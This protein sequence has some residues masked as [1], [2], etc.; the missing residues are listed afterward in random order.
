MLLNKATTD[1][2]K[3]RIYC[4]LAKYY[5]D[6]NIDTAEIYI[7]QASEL[8]N[9]GQ[10]P[11]LQ[12]SV[13]LVKADINY[14]KGNFLNARD[15]Y[16]KLIFLQ[17]TI[18]DIKRLPQTYNGL[19][20][21][22]LFLGELDSSKTFFS[23]SLAEY[24]R[25]G[26]KVGIGE[27][28]NNLGIINTYSGDY[29]EA[30][31]YLLKSAKIDEELNNEKGL[32]KVY[33]NIGLLYDDFKEYDNALKYYKLSLAI[34]E[35]LN[36]KKGLYSVLNNLGIVYK[37]LGQYEESLDCYKRAGFYGRSLGY[38]KG[39]GLTY[40]N[41]GLLYNLENNHL[42]ALEYHQKALAIEK[43]LEDSVRIAVDYINIAD[44]YRKMGY[45]TKG[46]A[47][48]KKG[49]EILEESKHLKK[50]M[51][52][53]EI[54]SET[55]FDL[56]EYEK[57]LSSYRY[58]SM[59]S[60]SIYNIE[61]NGQIAD[62][63]T[64]YET[65]KKEKEIL[66]LKEKTAQQE[67]QQAENKL[68]LE[69]RKKWI[70]GLVLG[71]A[72][73]IFLSLFLI[74]RNRRIEMAKRDAAIIR[75]RELGLK[76]VIE[77]Q[78]EE[79]KRIAKDLHDGIGQQLSGLKMAWQVL[80]K[81]ISNKTP[82][83]T[84]SLKMLTKTLDETTCEVRSI[85][86]QMM[87]RA[88]SEFGLVPAIQDMLKKCLDPTNLKYEFE[89]FKVEGRFAEN[90]EISLYRIT[91]ELVNNV[92]KHSGATEIAV[93]LIKSKS[94]LL[95]IVEDNGSGFNVKKENDGIGLMNIKSRLNTINGEVNFEPSPNSGM[96][97]TIRIP[98]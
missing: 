14:E 18:N 79:R 48:I 21:T 88:L 12:I 84:K 10:S 25:K 76:A 92:I 31:Q 68:E 59:L 77:G 38:Q 3:A 91:Q 74:Q 49:I 2:S 97:A 9:N 51:D 42:L 95:L 5:Q 52:A 70:V 16:M 33:N 23:L 36:D 82:E 93:Q 85:S 15:L 57:A 90:V 28:T 62:I 19:G 58:F 6:I 75:E 65:E 35:R 71:I 1:T 64:K 30:I 7:N 11:Y 66:V 54:L 67:R 13:Y 69:N 81:R 80:S 34:R 94:K 39:L 46:L 41:I 55:Y 32:A 50:T 27:L 63:E 40:G 72:S 45:P 26:N 61:K 73:I 83:E 89:H 4:D 24:E 17:S 20:K 87:P 29:S 86:H 56:G 22:Y 60:D 53:F 98:V 8:L 37:N 47:M 43:E 78:E 96:V 44:T